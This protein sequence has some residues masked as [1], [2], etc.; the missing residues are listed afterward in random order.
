MTRTLSSSP[1]PSSPP[2][3]IP[4]PR[5]PSPPS[6][7][8]H[9]AHLP[10]KNKNKKVVWRLYLSHFLSTWNS[11]TFEFGAVLFLAQTF[12]GT[13]TYASV[14]ALVR[15]LA[16]VTLSSWVGQRLDRVDRL[17]AVR[18]SIGERHCIQYRLL[19]G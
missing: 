10:H 1:P 14:Y 18:H 5:S 4:S 3:S 9:H 2:P 19:I 17:V 11:R 12:V 13:L 16:A 7:S 8:P 15:S 6:P